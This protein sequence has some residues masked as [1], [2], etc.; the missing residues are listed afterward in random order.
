MIL[1]LHTDGDSGCCTLDGK[2]MKTSLYDDYLIMI[3]EDQKS[4]FIESWYSR[5]LGISDRVYETLE[6]IFEN[7]VYCLMN[8]IEEKF[9]NGNYSIN[10]FKRIDLY[11]IKG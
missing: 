2:L 4:L 1:M 10:L 11:T 3:N 6:P 7:V 8:D 9:E 5:K